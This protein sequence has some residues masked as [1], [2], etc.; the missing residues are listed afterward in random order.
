MA[1]NLMRIM[2]SREESAFAEDFL[3]EK[4]AEETAQAGAVR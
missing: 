1:M 4:I 2:L 3:A